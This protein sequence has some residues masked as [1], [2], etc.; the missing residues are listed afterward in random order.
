MD[1]PALTGLALVG[2]Q[3]HL[4]WPGASVNP[5]AGTGGEHIQS[6]QLLWPIPGSHGAGPPPLG[7]IT[8]RGELGHGHRGQAAPGRTSDI[9]IFQPGCQNESFI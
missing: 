9:T 6:H 7:S 2:K 5:V 1:P 4:L 3:G 8:S